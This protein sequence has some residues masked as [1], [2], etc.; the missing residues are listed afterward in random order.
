MQW[1][2]R[3]EVRTS[4]GKVTTTELLAFS[5]PV[6]VS[7]LAEIGLMAHWQHPCKFITVINDSRCPTRRV[8]CLINGLRRRE[9]HHR[10]GIQ[11][12]RCPLGS[13]RFTTTSEVEGWPQVDSSW[14]IVSENAPSSLESRHSL[15]RLGFREFTPA[16]GSHGVART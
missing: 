4:A 15:Q 6:V 11:P 9:E 7:T 8:P 3:L 1:T 14:V 12:L 2:V 16:A 10:P 5:R 13:I